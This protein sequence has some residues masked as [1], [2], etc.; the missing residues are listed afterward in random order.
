MVVGL[1]VARPGGVD[2]RHS[3]P[4]PAQRV[5]VAR[6]AAHEARVLVAVDVDAHVHGV[7]QLL[8]VEGHEPLNQ[9]HPARPR[10]ELLPDTL[11]GRSRVRLRAARRVS[12]RAPAR[13][14][15]R[16]QEGAGAHREVVDRDLDLLAVAQPLEVCDELLRVQRVRAVPVPAAIAVDVHLVLV[17]AVVAA[18]AP[19]PVSGDVVWDGRLAALQLR[20]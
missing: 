4:T 5:G 3:A 10:L 14:A 7:A 20:A 2:V 8:V 11:A 12:R 18:R 19:S 6:E 13:P 15:A 9:Q 16:G 1:H 17:V